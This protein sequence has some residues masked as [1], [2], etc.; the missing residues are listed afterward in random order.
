M[1]Y[2]RPLRSWAAR[3]AAVVLLSPLAPAA[4]QV[5]IPVQEQVQL[6]NSLPPAQQQALIR[7]MQRSLPPAQR[8][9]VIEML[10][11][12][13]GGAAALGGG[14][15]SE[16]GAVDE[17]GLP[18]ESSGLDALGLREEEVPRLEARSTLVIEFA[19]RTDA[20]AVGP[21]EQRRID[22]FRDRLAK[23]NPYQL[24]GAG[25]LYLPG[26]RAM[27]LA[28]LDVDQATVRVRTEPQLSPF[29]PTI[30]FLPLEPG[31][32]PFGYDTF[33]QAPRRFQTSLY[34]VPVPAE[35]VIGPGDTINVQ[36]FGNENMEYFL[37]VQ[38]D[39][40]INFP[41]IGPLN[42]SGQSFDEMR[43]TITDRV[44]RQMIGVRASITLG[45]LRSIQVFVVGEVLR[46]GSYTVTGLAP[47]SA[48]FA[49]PS[50]VIAFIS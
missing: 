31:I 14:E 50:F 36:L 49:G 44:E 34:D 48:A 26:V 43:A 45:E 12:Q 47:I 17:D 1:S 15:V 41:E 46:P 28:G 22:D 38:R 18:I 7:E 5:P 16:E 30:T 6:F 21:E 40:T 35:Y 10:Q 24:D 2:L 37:P 4:A 23:G 11:R 20:P 42:V 8:Q 3:A 19:P 29:T 32:R 39:G 27:E 9:A 13:G 33:R 25:I